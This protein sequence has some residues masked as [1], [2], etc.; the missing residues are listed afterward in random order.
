MGNS[1]K[2]SLNLFKII[3]FIP[4]II[5]LSQGLV[6]FS[7]QETKLIW[8]IILHVHC[9]ENNNPTLFFIN[10]STVVAS[11]GIENIFQIVYP[12]IPNPKIQT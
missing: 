11:P 2:I 8:F 1:F 5:V 10:Q 7:A 4:K 9:N 6:S 12:K 3:L